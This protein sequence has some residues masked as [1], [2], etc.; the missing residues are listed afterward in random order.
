MENLKVTLTELDK[1]IYNLS[2]GTTFI[3][4]F[5]RSDLRYLIEQIDNGIGSGL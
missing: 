2:I 3:G 4:Q 1:D 5:E